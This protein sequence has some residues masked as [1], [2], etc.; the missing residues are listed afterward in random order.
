MDKNVGYRRVHTCHGPD[1]VSWIW[2]L[3]CRGLYLA[4]KG[5]CSIQYIHECIYLYINAQHTCM[6]E[7]FMDRLYASLVSCPSIQAFFRTLFKCKV[8]RDEAL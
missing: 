6:Y 8:S 1:G 4:G 7:A 3:S 5:E 2:T